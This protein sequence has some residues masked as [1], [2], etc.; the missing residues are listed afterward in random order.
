MPRAVFLSCLSCVW[1]ASVLGAQPAAS[2]LRTTAPV[3]GSAGAGLTGPSRFDPRMRVYLVPTRIVWQSQQRQA[4]VEHSEVL[5]KAGSG[6]VTLE[7]PAACTLRNKGS[8]PAILL[9]F[10][11]EI[12][13]GVQIMV[14]GSAPT[15]RFDCGFASASRPAKR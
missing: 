8:E 6:Q 15:N 11:R 7:T 5:L 1:S 9:D 4:E 12:H 2:L 14:S 10:G 13:G 3:P